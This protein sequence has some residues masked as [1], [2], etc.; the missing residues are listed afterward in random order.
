MIVRPFK[1]CGVHFNPGALKK[2]L[3]LTGHYP[4][5]IINLLKEILFI[6]NAQQSKIYVTDADVELATKKLLCK[7]AIFNYICSDARRTA[8]AENCLHILATSRWSSHYQL[9]YATERSS[10]YITEGDL[11]SLLAKDT[12]FSKSEARLAV[13]QLVE[14][15]ILDKQFHHAGIISY[16]FSIPLF[17]HWLQKSTSW[18]R[19]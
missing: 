5:Y 17:H 9:E 13:E 16:K 6:L 2:V 10:S 12:H 8:F 4:Y 7:D 11:F 14:D 19:K 1:Q 18:L 15:K 3:F